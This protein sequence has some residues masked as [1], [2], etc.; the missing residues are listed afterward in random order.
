MQPHIRA[1]ETMRAVVLNAL[2]KNLAHFLAGN[3][4][5]NFINIQVTSMRSDLQ[6]FVRHIKQ[7]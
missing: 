1:A 6:Y 3:G 5:V 4:R 7:G 2:S